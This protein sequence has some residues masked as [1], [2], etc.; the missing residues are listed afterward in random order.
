MFFATVWVPE[1]RGALLKPC[2]TIDRVLEDDERPSPRK[3]G[4]GGWV[5]SRFRDRLAN[6]TEAASA[7]TESVL[8]IWRLRTEEEEG[9]KDPV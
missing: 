4:D 7:I 1:L 9:P 2:R 6:I 3:F 5:P 8:A